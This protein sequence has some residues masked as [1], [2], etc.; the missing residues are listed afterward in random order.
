VR[1]P[2]VED[3][4][5][6]LLALLSLA[7]A[8]GWLL[9]V[10]GW[11]Q[12]AHWALARAL[13]DGVP[14][15]DRTIGEIGELGSGDTATHDGHLYTVKPPGLA[16]A[17]VPWYA[18]VSATGVRT[19]G[20]PTRPVWLMN[21]WGSV[22]PALL[23]VVAIWWLAERLEPGL[24]P[25]T[26]AI[27]GLG[28][29]VLAFATLFFSHSLS[30]LLGF[31]PFAVLW[32][33]R[34]G[35]QRLRLVALAGLLIGLGFT[36]DYQIGFGVGVVLGLYAALRGRRPQLLAT[37]LGAYVAGALVGALPNFA[38]NWWAFGSPLHSIYEDFW[39]EHPGL[40]ATLNPY[41]ISPDWDSAS[42]M[43]FSTM[44]LFTLAPVLLLG[45]VGIGLLVRRRLVAEA[46][47]VAGVCLVVGIYQAGLGAF[48]GQGPPRYLMTLVPYL[49]LPI[50]LALRAFPLTTVALAS[51]SIFQA[52]V[53]T[54]TGPLAAYDGEWLERARERNF[55][56]TAASVVDVTGWYTILVFFL[57]VVAAVGCAVLASR[58]LMI[59]ASEWPMA[60]AGL[61]VWVVMALRAT[62]PVGLPPS[63]RYVLSAALGGAAAAAVAYAAWAPRGHG[64]LRRS[65]A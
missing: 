27:V 2:P 26:A 57:A 51:I 3:R 64:F 28:T 6:A 44:G 31:L 59:R 1:L 34:H 11:N 24:G 15:I 17:T 48:G 38:F 58:P 46:L 22:L 14:Y 45:V 39:R 12:N 20:E 10:N 50:A 13:A 61:G 63:T 32:H 52:V 35:P 42:A 29:M 55:M 25:L 65:P 4:R 47:V 21:L 9:Q 40:K 56:L 23:L 53:Q 30:T 36:V 62:N 54:A 37:R 19:A 60:V 18:A 43:L 7:V 16:L 41:A 5:W 33:E 8:F 49:G